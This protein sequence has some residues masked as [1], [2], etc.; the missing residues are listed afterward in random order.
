VVDAEVKV[1][2]VATTA[3]LPVTYSERSCIRLGLR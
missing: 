1:V 2:A 3:N